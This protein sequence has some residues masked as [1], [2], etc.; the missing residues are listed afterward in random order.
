MNSPTIWMVKIY[1]PEAESVKWRFLLRFLG[2]E[3]TLLKNEKELS[4]ALVHD[5]PGMVIFDRALLGEA[6]AAIEVICSQWLERGGGIALTGQD[7]HWPLPDPFLAKVTDI[8]E[9][10]PF[11]INALLQRFVPTYSRLHPRLGTRL[12]GLYER[13]AGNCQICE[14]MNLSPGGAFIRTTATLPLSGEEL[15]VYVPLIGMHKEIKLSS[16]VVRQILPNEANNY[17]QGIGVSFVVDKN[18]PI[19]LELNNYVRYVLAH[20]ETLDPQV[21]P[22]SGCRT[23]RKEFAVKSLMSR[24]VKGRERSLAPIR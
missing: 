9:R 8:S 1:Q 4:H 3:S 12:P 21:T 15:L 19:F 6:F 2:V 22:F 7:G 11:T 10:D 24:S 5:Q 18:S 13:A 14:I 20:D 16:R 17:T 23:R